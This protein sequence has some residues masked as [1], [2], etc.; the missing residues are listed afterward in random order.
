M[1][2]I[3]DILTEEH[4]NILRFIDTLLKEC[5]Q[6]ENGKSVDKEFFK[7]AIDFIRNYADKFHHA[8][9]EELLFKEM[10]KCADDGCLHCNPVEQMIFEHDE[11]RNFVKEMEKGVESNDKK[12]VVENARG[13]SG[14]LQQ[15]I[16]KEDNILYP[17]AESALTDDVKKKMIK[18]FIEIENKR[19]KDKEKYEKFVRG[20]M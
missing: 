15:H 13:Y 6:I 8:K 17:M 14:L 5:D 11:G 18:E 4:K 12:R 7:N 2:K 10:N 20:L 3:S 16:F 19:K 9:E 1:S